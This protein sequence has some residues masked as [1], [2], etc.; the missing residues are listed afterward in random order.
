MYCLSF[1]FIR[2]LFLFVLV[3]HSNT[4]RINCKQGNLFLKVQEAEKSKIKVLGCGEAF[5]LHLHKVEGAKLL[6]QG[7]LTVLVDYFYI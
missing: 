1:I 3:F 6:P 4:D 2:I 7:L 5:L